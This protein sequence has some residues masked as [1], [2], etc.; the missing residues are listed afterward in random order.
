MKLRKFWVVGWGGRWG[1]PIRS[2]TGSRLSEKMKLEKKTK[3]KFWYDALLFSIIWLSLNF[4]HVGRNDDK[5]MRQ[6]ISLELGGWARFVAAYRD[7]STLLKKK[8]GGP[9]LPV[10]ILIVMMPVSFFHIY[11][12]WFSF[13]TFLV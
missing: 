10:S 12:Y 4:L 13:A 1:A 2:A 9:V 5:T 11:I 3:I 6:V 7:K 8:G